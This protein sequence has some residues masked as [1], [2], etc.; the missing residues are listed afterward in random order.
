MTTYTGKT[1]F[2]LTIPPKATSMTIT[3]VGGGGGSGSGGASGGSGAKLVAS[4]NIN[5]NSKPLIIYTGGKGGGGAGGAG[6]GGG[7][8]TTVKFNANLVGNYIITD[9]TLGPVINIV[10]G[11]GGGGGGGGIQYSGGDGGN[12]ELQLGN[13]LQEI[14]TGAIGYNGAIGIQY[15]GEGGGGK[16]AGDSAGDI[17]LGG[18][19]GERGGTD[20][21]LEGGDG[22]SN[23]F[24]G[25]AGGDGGG[26]GGGGGGYGGEGE[27]GAGGGDGAGRGTGGSNGGGGGGDGG[28]GGGGGLSGGGGGGASSA[29]G[30]GGGSST[31]IFSYYSNVLTMPTNPFISTNYSKANNAGQDGYVTISFGYPVISITSIIPGS[32]VDN[33]ETLT[34]NG[35][36]FDSDASV[37]SS[38]GIGSITHISPSQITFIPSGLSGSQTVTVTVTNT[39]SSGLSA[40]G[41]YTTALAPS[42][43]TIAAPNSYFINGATLTINGSNF[44]TGATVSVNGGAPFLAGYS[45]PSSLSFTAPDITKGATVPVIVT[46]PNGFS[47]N[48]ISITYDSLPTISNITAPNSYFI[49]GATLTII[50]TNFGNGAKV[51]NSAAGSTQYD[52]FYNSS[53]NL[54]F[55]APSG[56][57]NSI[58]VVNPNGLPSNAYTRFEYDSPPIFTDYT[59]R[60]GVVSNKS[61]T[62]T[63]TNI[64]S[65][66]TLSFSNITPSP[67]ASFQDSTGSITFLA[68]TNPPGTSLPFTITN[69]DTLTATGTLQYDSIPIITTVDAT[70]KGIISTALINIHGNYFDPNATVNIINVFDASSANI[71]SPSI[72]TT[73]ISFNIPPNLI[74]AGGSPVT[75]TITNPSGLSVNTVLQSNTSPQITLDKVSGISNEIVT[76]INNGPTPFYNIAPPLN[77]DF[78]GTILNPITITDTEIEIELPY[79]PIDDTIIYIITITNGD[80]LVSNPIYF[81]YSFPVIYFLTLTGT[82]KKITSGISGLPITIYGKGFIASGFDLYVDNKLQPSERISNNQINFIMPPGFLCYNVPIYVITRIDKIKSNIVY[83]TFTPP[84]STYPIDQQNV[85][86]TRA[87]TLC[88]LPNKR[89]TIT[90]TQNSARQTKNQQ[91]SYLSNQ[92]TITQP[93]PLP[94]NPP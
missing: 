7:G 55:T 85:P 32:N 34:I 12:V 45:S 65:G 81:I 46:N 42:I 68:P 78:S 37:T 38:A 63:G 17:G 39:N 64:L 27:G 60:Y 9:P 87:T 5:D 94:I 18:R 23:G 13:N 92:Q 43:T 91:W 54:T 57:S 69:P 90:Y 74:T 93:C 28:G 21:G 79:I 33:G 26:G 73:D 1:N 75:F 52:T 71:V 67:Y 24:G 16:Y 10:A 86:P 82:D 30:G 62:I 80:G 76:I 53:T 58:I 14:G 2:S 29:G 11:G 77:V 25:L 61:V 88:F 15:S 84:S 66:A 56:L 4:F 8:K 50:G 22:G 40:T 35:A 36:N 47:S 31:I 6:G 83:Y 3:A 59:P 48:S 20:A 49:V 72:T 89:N 19:G 44:I 51:Q 41:N 70:Q